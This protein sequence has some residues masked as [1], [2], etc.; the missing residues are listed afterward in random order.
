M[1]A[2][3]QHKRGDTFDRVLLIP[4]STF[5]DGYFLLWDVAS[6]IRTARGKFVADL[7]ATWAD[8][9]ADTRFLR[10]FYEPTTAWPL[11]DLELDVQL[12]RQ[13]DGFIQSTE[14]ITVQVLRDVTL[15]A[16]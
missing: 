9:A 7:T 13:S 1:A 12:T 15:V 2:T 10:L 4:E 3:I 16:P 14:T 6:Q 5:A 8:P 11:G